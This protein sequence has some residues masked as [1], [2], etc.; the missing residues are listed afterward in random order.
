MLSLGSVPDETDPLIVV[1]VG[2]TACVAELLPHPAAAA[3]A[4]KARP[5]R[6]NK[7]PGRT[8]WRRS[9]RGMRECGSEP[10]VVFTV[11]DPRTMVNVPGS[12]LASDCARRQLRVEHFAGA[13]SS[14]YGKSCRV[15]CAD[16]DQ[17]ACLVPI[18]MFVRDLAVFHACND[19]HGHFDVLSG[20]GNAGK[21]P[22]DWLCVR[23]ADDE[24]VDDL[25]GAHRP[26][27]LRHGDV[28]R[29]KL[30]YQVIPIEVLHA[31]T[32]DAAH[33][34]GDIGQM[35]ILRHGGHGRLEVAV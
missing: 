17:D 18:D 26:G 9:V 33:H 28:R 30:S 11:V 35:R 10:R 25:I 22:V 21:H 2:G 34:V 3:M 19:D 7:R 29:K 16:L 6:E 31:L 14:A 24:F 15:E 32:T 1:L 8:A 23:K 5:A 20:R 27:D 12:C 4:R 13:F